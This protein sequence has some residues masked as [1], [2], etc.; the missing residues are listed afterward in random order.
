MESETD[1]ERIYKSPEFLEL[2]ESFIS[3]GKPSE[4]RAESRNKSEVVKSPTFS[5]EELHHKLTSTQP[6]KY[7]SELESL[8]F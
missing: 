3:R 8:V 1:E 5:K 2:T 4:T 7:E 6:P